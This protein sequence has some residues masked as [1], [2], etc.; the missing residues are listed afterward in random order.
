MVIHGPHSLKQDAAKLF[1]KPYVYVHIFFSIHIS[2]LSNTNV[3]KNVS[4]IVFLPKML[5]Q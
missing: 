4:G 5:I 1:N 2:I 3:F